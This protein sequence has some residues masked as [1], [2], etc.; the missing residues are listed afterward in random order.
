MKRFL[1]ETMAY[2]M[3]TRVSH[4]LV[5]LHLLKHP[6]KLFGH[7]KNHVQLLIHHAELFISLLSV[8]LSSMV[9]GFASHALFG[10]GLENFTCGFDM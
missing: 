8:S 10:H 6:R 9:W 2:I 5:W 1:F 7:Q 3:F 4:S